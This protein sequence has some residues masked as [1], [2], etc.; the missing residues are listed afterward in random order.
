MSRPASLFNADAVAEER[1]Q[2]AM[3][4]GDFD[5]LPGAGRPLDLD[6][7]P[8]VPPELR[9]ANRILKNAGCV[10]PELIE[11]REMAALEASLPDL[12]EEARKRAIAKLA[13][14]RM[15]LGPRSG[16]A[17]GVNRFYERRMIE[18]LAGA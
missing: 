3:R 4:R 17:L 11:R 2:E 10:P 8:L 18:K 12:G 7:D 16:L 9:V 6:E 1:I 13:V 5:H 15:R 14:M